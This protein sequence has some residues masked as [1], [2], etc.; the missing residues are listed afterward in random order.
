MLRYFNFLYISPLDQKG[1]ALR[2]SLKILQTTIILI[3][4]IINSWNRNPISN[5]YTH[6]TQSSIKCINAMRFILQHAKV[7]FY[8]PF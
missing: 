4:G 3:I 1:S 2:F 7:I 8:F 6:S 5:F